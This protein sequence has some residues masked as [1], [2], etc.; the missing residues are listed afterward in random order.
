VW[1]DA[2]LSANPEKPGYTCCIDD[3]HADPGEVLEK[4]ID[5]VFLV[6]RSGVGV[7]VVSAET[8]LDQPVRVDGGWQWASD[9]V[10][11]LVEFEIR[12]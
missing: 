8:I 11:L 2:H 3:L 1:I 6:P 4:R 7:E 5:Y 10:G 12:P 9:H